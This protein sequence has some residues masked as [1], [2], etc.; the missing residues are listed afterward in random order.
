MQQDSARAHPCIAHR[1]NAAHAAGLCARAPVRGEVHALRPAGA[2][3][4][5]QRARGSQSRLARVL[6]EH[7]VAVARRGARQRAHNG[8]L[9]IR[10]EALRPGSDENND[11][12]L[13]P[14][15]RSQRLPPARTHVPA[16]AL[17]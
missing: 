3:S 17:H 16:A 6:G 15:A 12:S 13:Q 9:Q 2:H 4:A 1:D 14:A 5:Q 8:W 10:I 11:Q 7:D